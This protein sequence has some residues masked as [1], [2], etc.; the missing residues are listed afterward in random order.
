MALQTSGAISLNDIHV[1]AG[2]SSGTQASMNDSDI[3][4]LIDKSSGAQMAFNEWYGASNVVAPPAGVHRITFTV[5]LQS[6][7]IG[8]NTYYYNTTSFSIIGGTQASRQL[9]QLSFFG[10]I[11]SNNLSQLTNVGQ[12]LIRTNGSNITNPSFTLFPEIDTYDSRMK[13]TDN[14]NNQI[15]EARFGN[16][17]HPPPSFPTN[18]SSATRRPTGNYHFDLGECGAPNEYMWTYY[19]GGTYYN[20]FDITFGQPYKI[21]FES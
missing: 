21:F 9:N 8:G 11:S 7:V 6:Q 10:T 16:A 19:Q 5:N 20:F 2:G 18:P 12:I 4:G 1:E 14:N 13:I 3:R 15:F 17:I